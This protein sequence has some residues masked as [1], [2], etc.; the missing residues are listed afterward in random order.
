MGYSISQETYERLKKFDAEGR[1]C[2]L[3]RCTKRAT[4]VLTMTTQQVNA[5]GT[6]S[7]PMNRNADDSYVQTFCGACKTKMLRAYEV[8]GK[9]VEGLPGALRYE[10]GYLGAT[11]GN[12][13][14]QVNTLLSTRKLSR[15]EV[16]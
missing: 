12:T 13:S 5:D 7:Q 10:V 14:K 6:V 15:K 8:Y 3:D 4:Y 2:K 9:P 11:S 1:R 16:L